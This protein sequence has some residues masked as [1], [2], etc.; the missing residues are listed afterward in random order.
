MK[1]A[2]KQFE[3]ARSVLKPYSSEL[4][5][6]YDVSTFVDKPENDS[7]DCI[8]PDSGAEVLPP[9]LSLL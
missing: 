4:M 1:S 6:A 7:A 5:D 3:K 9:Q 8:R 2:R